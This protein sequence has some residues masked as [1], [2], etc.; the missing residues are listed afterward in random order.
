[1]PQI[2]EQYQT[3]TSSPTRSKLKECERHLKRYIRQGLLP[4]LQIIQAEATQIYKEQMQATIYRQKQVKQAK[5]NPNY[6]IRTESGE[7]VMSKNEC[8]VA[9]MLHHH[10]IP[11]FYEKPLNLKPRKDGT[12]VTLHPDFT[13]SVNGKNIY[14]EVLGMMDT[15]AYANSWEYRMTTYKINGIQIGKNLVALQVPQDVDCDKVRQVLT[16]LTKHKVP[17]KIVYCGV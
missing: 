13:I 8:I 15:E 4:S 12:P 11:Y 2:Q 9:N 3:R 14:I 5:D 7:L 17:Q 1:M 10:K 16:V 6:K